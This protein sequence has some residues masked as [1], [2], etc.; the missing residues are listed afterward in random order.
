[1]SKI[2]KIPI[3][4]PSNVQVNIGSDTIK[5]KGPRGELFQIYNSH[6]NVISCEQDSEINLSF[7]P[8]TT[9]PLAWSHAGTVRAVVNNMIIGVTDGFA[10]TLEL[11][12]VGYRAQVNN[13]TLNLSLGYSHPIEYQL[14]AG[15]FA[16]TPNNTTIILKGIDKQL[17]GQVA[18][19]VRGYRPPE[20]YKG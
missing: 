6:V 20:P 12:G 1:M 19:E 7:Q 16:E 9:H 11:V 13:T 14:P 10:L 5:V 4:L 15:V 18:S 3:K 8:A 17:I 2:A